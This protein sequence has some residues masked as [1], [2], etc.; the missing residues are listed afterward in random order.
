MRRFLLSKDHNISTTYNVKNVQFGIEEIQLVP[1][2]PAMPIAVNL[3]SIATGAD[4][5]L[6]NLKNVGTTVVKADSSANNALFSAD[7]SGSVDGSSSDLVVEYI[8]PDYKLNTAQQGVFFPGANKAGQ[9]EPSYILANNC[10][11]NTPTDFTNIGYTVDLAMVVNGA[12]AG[13]VSRSENLQEGYFQEGNSHSYQGSLLQT[14]N[15]ILR[16]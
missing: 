6:A 16:P 1:A 10:S 4:L 7:V 8:V 2:T 5:T 3:Y 15:I 14:K 11:I 9:T 13:Q 12:S